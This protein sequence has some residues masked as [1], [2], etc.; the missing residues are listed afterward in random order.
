MAAANL[1][2]YSHNYLHLNKKVIKVN[3]ITNSSVLFEEFYS[4]HWLEISPKAFYKGYFLK[5]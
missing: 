4:K 1:H 2:F 3:L 5:I